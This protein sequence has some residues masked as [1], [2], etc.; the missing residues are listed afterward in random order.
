M[1]IQIFDPTPRPSQAGMLGQALGVGLGKLSERKQR[2]QQQSQ[3]ARTLFGEEAEQYGGL[4]AEQ[5]L[6]IAQMQQQQQQEAQKQMAQQ[7]KSDFIASLLD[8]TQTD[9][10]VPGE[11]GAQPLQPSAGDG[12]PQA[13]TE[14]RKFSQRDLIAINQADPQLAK[15]IQAEQEQQ[16]K[17]QQKLESETRKETLPFKQKVIEEAN[18]AREAIQ[19]K[20]QLLNLIDTENLTDP[21]VASLLTALPFKL[22]ER[23]RNPSLGS[24]SV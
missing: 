13:P 21:T 7:Q 4:P 17:H 16:E 6:Q 22:G 2:E 11:P 10:G 15:L 9:Q 1:S 5:Q 3:L 8:P 12:L 20:E 24:A 14:R 23:G 19:N 18:S